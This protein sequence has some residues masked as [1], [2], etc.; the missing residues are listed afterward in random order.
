VNNTAI[1]IPARLAS[2][3]FPKKMLA[4]LNG[5]SLIRTVYDKCVATGLDTFVLTDS[6]EITKEIP[7]EHVRITPDADNGT[8][9]CA[10]GVEALSGKG[11]FRRA[12]GVYKSYINVQGDMPDITEDII[13]AIK[14]GLD[15]GYKVV[16][17]YTDMDPELRTDPNSVKMIHNGTYAHWFCRAS[18]EY[19][20]GYDWRTLVGYKSMPQSQEEKIEKL[21]QLRFLQNGV[22]I[23]IRKVDFDGMEINTPEDLEKWLTKN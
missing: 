1:L 20:D 10:Y 16:T 4:D 11:F 17:A 13:L 23:N 9:R 19:G 22:S 2:T 12:T 5:K 7:A 3:R 18:L 21:E 15:E 6:A 14:Q 8:E